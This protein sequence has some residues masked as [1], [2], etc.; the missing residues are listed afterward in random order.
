MSVMSHIDLCRKN[1]ERITR[2]DCADGVKRW[3]CTDC[4]SSAL[5][6]N[7]LQHPMTCENFLSAQARRQV[8]EGLNA[9]FASRSCAKSKQGV[10]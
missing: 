4:L 3:V 5:K 9:Y 6:K 7:D 1:G 2:I 10:N 8:R